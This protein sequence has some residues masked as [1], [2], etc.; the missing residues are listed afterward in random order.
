MPNLNHGSDRV[1]TCCD[2]RR[3]SAIKGFIKRAI[4]AL[5]GYRHLCLL[6]R[7]YGPSGMA[8]MERVP[9]APGSQVLV[10]SVAG[11]L[12][13]SRPERCSIAKK[14]FWTRGVCKPPED[15]IALNLFGIVAR[16]SEVALDIGANSG[17]FSLVAAKANPQIRVIAFD[18]LPE[19][20]HI[21]SD[22][23]ILN[24]LLDRV[25]VQ[26][27]GVG[28]SGDVFF[29]P[30]DKVSSEMP[31]AVSL[32]MRVDGW[33]VRVPVKSL[34]EICLPRF[35]NR[36][37]CVKIDVEG[38]EASIFANGRETLTTTGPDIICEVLPTA[39]DLEQYDRLLSRCAYNKFLITD[40]GLSQ[41]SKIDPHKRF[42]D[43]FLTKGNCTDLVGTDLLCDYG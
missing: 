19:A 4:P 38:N 40:T 29:A 33:Q 15:R 5:P 1:A 17:L 18:I 26:L 2:L 12:F 42:K 21:L 9:I 36:R 37:L 43:W 23:L 16:R 25:E 39:K 34:D 7:N 20:Y 8:W 11:D 32:D 3:G 13:L 28:K 27:V 31:S 41:Q 10:H 14:L 35:A 22:N 30:F 6:L 24:G